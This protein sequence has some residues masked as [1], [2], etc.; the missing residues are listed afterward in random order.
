MRLTV[1]VWGK[2]VVTAFAFAKGTFSSAWSE[3]EVTV[4][5]DLL[6]T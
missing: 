5:A 4:G 6:I 2:L 1:L 3:E